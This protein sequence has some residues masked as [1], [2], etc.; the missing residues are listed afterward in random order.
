MNKL[1]TAEES[2]EKWL[3]DV[4]IGLGLCP[5]ATQPYAQKQIRISIY[6]GPADSDLLQT[7]NDEYRRLAAQIPEQPDYCETTL[8]ACSE[9]LDDFYDYN[10]FLALANSH[11][12]QMGWHGQFQLA[13]FHPDYQFAGTEKNDRENLTNR[14]PL[15]IFH[16]IRESSLSAALEHYPEPERIYERNIQTVNTLNT[17]QLHRLFSHLNLHT[18]E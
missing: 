6:S 4:V 5:F 13:S 1:I 9:A 14:S 8:I 15:P 3:R 7:L 17:T 18:D 12:E 11:L 16:I 10:D 2:I